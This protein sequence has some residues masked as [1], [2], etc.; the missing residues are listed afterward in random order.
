M[1][2]AKATSGT[3]FLDC[4][5]AAKNADYKPL[6]KTHMVDVC[7][8]P[9]ARSLAIAQLVMEMNSSNVDEL[10][11]AFLTHVTMMSPRLWMSR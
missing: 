5:P 7:G 6:A 2:P 3:R 11:S 4:Q 9:W 1:I 10:A 8:P